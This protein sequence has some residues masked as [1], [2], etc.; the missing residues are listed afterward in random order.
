ME[1][2][3]RIFT[4]LTLAHWSRSPGW[5]VEIYDRFGDLTGVLSSEGKL[6]LVSDKDFADQL[7][8]L[9]YG[10]VLQV[11]DAP[12]I[13]PPTGRIRLRELKKDGKYHTS[14]TSAMVTDIEVKRDGDLIALLSRGL[15]PDMWSWSE[16]S[17]DDF[18]EVCKQQGRGLYQENVDELV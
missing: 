4:G 10:R 7:F 18:K 9:G 3:A 1:C 15:A 8:R 12:Q 13:E 5:L 14:L 17:D 11:E 16:E 6:Y 2:Q